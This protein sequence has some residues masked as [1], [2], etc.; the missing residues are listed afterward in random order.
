[1]RVSEAIA[2]QNVERVQ[3]ALAAGAI[4]GTW[5]WDVP[6]DRI[7]IDEGF[8]HA[9]GLDPALGL[10]GLSIAQVTDSVHPEDLSSHEEAISTALA[11][12]AYVHQCRV[13]RADGKYY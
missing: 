1:M 11:G 8:S 5:H 6:N 9:F 3:L 4:I 10:E 12:G 13:R 7:T 2:R